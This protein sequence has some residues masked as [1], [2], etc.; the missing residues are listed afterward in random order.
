MNDQPQFVDLPPIPT[1]FPTIRGLADI[2]ALESVPP[3]ERVRGVSGSGAAER[4]A[5]EE[6]I[7]RVMK[8]H[9]LHYQVAFTA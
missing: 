1:T 6:A 4:T 9:V 2:E 5:V 3:G 7:L 8:A